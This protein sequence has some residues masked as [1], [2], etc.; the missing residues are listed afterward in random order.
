M[1]FANPL[2]PEVPGLQWP[3]IDAWISALQPIQNLQ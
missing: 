1:L 2:D 3:V